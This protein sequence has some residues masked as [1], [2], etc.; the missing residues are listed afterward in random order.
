MSCEAADISLSCDQS[1]RCPLMSRNLALISS[2]PTLQWP[3]AL[4]P[5]SRTVSQTPFLTQLPYNRIDNLIYVEDEIF[6]VSRVLRHA[7]SPALSCCRIFIRCF[8][9]AS[10]WKLILLVEYT[11]LLICLHCDVL[12]KTRLEFGRPAVP[13][14]P[15]DR[16]CESQSLPRTLPHHTSCLTLTPSLSFVRFHSPG[17]CNLATGVYLLIV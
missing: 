14:D 9:F 2:P 12:S 5:D 13:F 6:C 4:N 17:S 8:I 15:V 7:G 11:G 1:G 16:A 3:N 10:E